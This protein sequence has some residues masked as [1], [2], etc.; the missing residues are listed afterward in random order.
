MDNKFCEYCERI[1]GFDGRCH[2]ED[3]IAHEGPIKREWAVYFEKHV[4]KLHMR[5][6]IYNSF[7]EAQIAL[8]NAQAINT[9][10]KFYINAIPVKENL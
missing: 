8:K 6:G 4:S 9:I 2:N 7:E 10:D 5:Y 3:C 1:H